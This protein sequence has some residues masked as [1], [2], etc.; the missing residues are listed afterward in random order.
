MKIFLTPNPF[1]G[2]TEDFI[3]DTPGSPFDK[4]NQR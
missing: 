4:N 2:D 3:P 1:P